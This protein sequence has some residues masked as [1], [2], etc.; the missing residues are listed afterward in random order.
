VLITGTNGM[1]IGFDTGLIRAGETFTVAVELPRD[2]FTYTV[3]ISPT[4]FIT[5]VVVISYN[6]PQGSH[7]FV[8]PVEVTECGTNL[9]N[10]ADEMLSGVSIDIVPIAAF[11]QNMTNT[12]NLVANSPHPEPITNGHLVVDFVDDEGMVVYE[13][14]YTQTVQPGPNVLPVDFHPSTFDPPYQ[15]GEDYL[16]MAFFT[17]AQ[18]NIIDSHGRLLSTFAADPQPILHTAP[19]TCDIGTVVQ[20]ELLHKNISLVNTGLMPL[21]AVV[22]SPTSTLTLSNATGI[23]SV[24]PAGTHDVLATL[25]TT[26]LSGTVALSLTIRTNDPAHQTVVVPVMGTVTTPADPAVAFNLANRGWDKRVRVYGNVLQNNPVQFSPGIQPDTATIEPCKVFDPL[27]RLLRGVGKYCTDLAVGTVTSQIFGSGRD[28]DV[29]VTNGQTYFVPAWDPFNGSPLYSIAPA[30]QG[31]ISVLRA[32]GF[33]VGDEIIIQQTQGAM[34]AGTY[35]F[36]TIAS[37]NLPGN[38][39]TLER[40]LQNTYRQEGSCTGGGTCYRSQVRTVPHYRNVTVQSGGVLTCRGWHYGIDEDA[41]GICAFRVSGTLTVQTGGLID[42]KGKGFRRGD[43]ITGQ[44]THGRRGEGIYGGWNEQTRNNSGNGGGAGSGSASHVGA[45]GSGGAYGTDGVTG[46]D[47]SSSSDPGIPGTAVGSGNLSTIF[48]GG[49]GGGGGFGYNNGSASG[50]GGMGGGI[51]YIGAAT[52]NISG[53]LRTDGNIGENQTGDTNG[54]GGGGAG[55]AVMLKARSANLGTGL[56][57]SAR[58]NGSPGIGAWFICGGHGAVGRVRVEYCDTQSGS[59]TNPATTPEQ[60][61][62]YVADKPDP[63]L[64]RLYV[65]DAVTNGRNYEMSF[66]RRYSFAAGGGTAFTPTLVLS[67]SY[68]SGVLDALVTNIGAGGPTSLRVDVGNTTIYSVTQNITQPTL[69]NLSGSALAA[70]VTAFVHARPPTSTISIPFQVTMN[71]PGDVIL[72]NLVLTPSVGIDLAVTTGDLELGC[73]GLPTCLASEEMSVPISVTVRNTGFQN[74]TSAVVGYYVGD[75]RA[76]GRLLG[77]SYVPSVAAGGGSTASFNWNTQS[78]TGPQTLYAFVDPP[79]AIV[80]ISNSNNIISQTLYIKTK[81]DLRVASVAFD[82][83]DV[84]EDEPVNATLVVSNSGETGALS[85]TL[86]LV[87]AGVRGDVV[88]DTVQ[89]GSIA[90]TSTV[91]LNSA[92][93]PTAF[94]MHTITFTTDLS[95]TVGESNEVNN[96]LTTT[97]FVGLRPPRLDAGAGSDVPYTATVGYGYLNGQTFDFGGDTLTS[98]VRYDGNGNVQY[99]F[100][101]LQPSR[102]YHLDATFFQVGDTFTQ[103]VKFDGVD[104]S[105]V[106]QMQDGTESITSIL[107]PSSVYT[108]GSMVVSFRRPSSGPAFVSEVYLVPIQYVYVDAGSGWDPSFS[109]G[110]GY[111]Y[112]ATNTYSSTLGGLDPVNTYRSAFGP[113]V[114]YLFANLSPTKEYAVDL[115]LYDG[116]ASTKVESATAYGHALTGCS[117]LAVNTIQ[118]AQCVISPSDYVSGTVEITISCVSCTGPRVNEI[119]IEELTRSVPGG[120]PPTPTP[121]PSPTPPGAQTTISSFGA[122]WSG[123]MVQVS[124]GTLQE[125]RTH[126]FELW[127]SPTINPPTW[128]LTRNENSLSN[129]A[130][131]TIPSTYMYNDTGVTV[132]Q[133]YYYMLTW[134]GAECG[135]QGGQYGQN[136]MAQAPVLRGHVTWQGRGTQP[137]VRQQWPLTMTLKLGTNV[138]TYTNMT[139][140]ASGYFTA[141]VAQRG[142]GTYQYWIKGPRYLAR[143]GSVVLNGDTITP[144]EMGVMLAGN[145]NDDTVIEIADFTILHATFGLVLGDPG[146]DARADFNGNNE[147]ELTDFTLLRG[148]FGA[149]GAPPLVGAGEGEGASKGAQPTQTPVPQSVIVGAHVELRPKAGAPPN[150]GTVR[151]GENFTLELWVTNPTTNTLL[152]QQSY[153]S[154]PREM[155]QN[156]LPSPNRSCVLTNTIVPDT[157]VFN[158]LLQNEVCNGS[159]ACTSR[160]ARLAPGTISFAS[161]LAPGAT[162]GAQGSFKIGELTF[163][164]TAPGE[165]HI[166]WQ[167]SPPAEANRDSKV[168]DFEGNVVSNRSMYDEYLVKITGT[169]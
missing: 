121:T 138:Y 89:A 43:A 122:Q 32:A 9:I 22:N 143:A 148:N 68:S 17:D 151:P 78:F 12:I 23:V 105:K 125:N 24:A 29:S 38:V 39:L 48:L 27:T 63:N 51:I 158:V 112:T 157:R 97:M 3:P 156:V 153:L 10:C 84:I 21:N 49:A 132:G 96:V 142:P 55:G 6:D 79:D 69:F 42:M 119:A 129:C 40:N 99:K 111:G 98:T 131:R 20:G 144:S 167:F 67:Q 155:L 62:C 82:H 37:I 76:G 154:F 152:G 18:G 87:S 45:G 107:V 30:N 127:R 128:T 75:P 4:S 58:G 160:G 80:E 115:T 133:T 61:S 123:S 36:A 74:A 25:D 95:N 31:N 77:N 13:R 169:R 14:V 70:A 15:A 44:G 113:S 91:T 47:S 7:K 54:G 104:S 141:S 16:L 140:D 88:T 1:Q 86:R 108:D 57:T 65:P 147:V 11:N 35:E 94:G 52:I 26:T 19:A 135:A 130:L 59:I 101:G 85:S 118:K 72:T 33:R 139:T 41:G 92:F 163:C 168:V 134:S 117:N 2:T 34:G 93:T 110:Y 46:C 64:V 146:Y 8:T 159:Q 114:K 90:P 166:K 106:I 109:A 149:A 126:H 161:S 165:A 50:L 116:A 83:T 102:S 164:P 81:P 120:P 137:D 162:I 66:G 28:G 100:D 53:T 145:A 124:W 150:G 73:P 56:V 71:R 60:V 5:P 103:T 136:A